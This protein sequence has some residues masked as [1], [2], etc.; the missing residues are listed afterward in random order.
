LGASGRKPGEVGFGCRERGRRIRRR[1]S[2]GGDQARPRLGDKPRRQLAK[3]LGISDV[4]LRNW[5]KQEKAERGGRPGGLSRDEREEL[6]RLRDENAKLRMEREI[7]AK[8]A[9][10]FAKESDGHPYPCPDRVPPE[11][12]GPAAAC[13]RGEKPRPRHPQ[14]HL[15]E[16]FGRAALQIVDGLS[17][18]P[19]RCYEAKRADDYQESAEDELPSAHQRSARASSD[20]AGWPCRAQSSRRRHP[21]NLDRSRHDQPEHTGTPL[22]GSGAASGIASHAT[23]AR[24]ALRVKPLPCHQWGTM[25]GVAAHHTG[26]RRRD[27]V[28]CASTR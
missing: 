22:R 11:Q 18:E 25:A 14:R 20:P 6:N 1:V 9:A 12:P 4:T 19:R 28:V 2:A 5:I 15:D 17:D 10:F 24:L 3:D 26:D 7:L 13:D 8:A 16:D 23:V 21:R 27:G